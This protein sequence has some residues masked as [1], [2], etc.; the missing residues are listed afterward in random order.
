MTFCIYSDFDITGSIIKCD[1][2]QISFQKSKINGKKYICE[3]EAEF[4]QSIEISSCNRWNN[5]F[6][7]GYINIFDSDCDL[8]S[9]G[10]LPADIY[11]QLCFKEPQAG[12]NVS[13]SFQK[14]K[15]EL[16]NTDNAEL[17]INKAGFHVN[18]KDFA[19]WKKNLFLQNVF[20]VVLILGLAM[21]CGFVLDMIWPFVLGGI[22]IVMTILFADFRKIRSIRKLQTEP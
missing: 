13:L 5:G 4:V 3:T 11:V 22:I 12:F 20:V 18:S 8:F 9:I 15:F 19:N 14:Q 21:L 2:N 1:D 17:C 10:Y 16:T 6:Y 7:N